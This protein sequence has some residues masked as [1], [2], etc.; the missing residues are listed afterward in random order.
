VI[1]D[2]GEV[3]EKKER[4]SIVGGTASWYFGNQFCGSSEKWT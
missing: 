4:S 1:T 2:A 3:V